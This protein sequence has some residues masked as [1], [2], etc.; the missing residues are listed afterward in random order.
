MNRWELMQ[1]VRKVVA[2]V[3]RT[4]LPQKV[5]KHVEREF[6]SEPVEYKSLSKTDLVTLLIERGIPHNKKSTKAELIKALQEG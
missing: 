4:K 1:D 3:Q 6:I 2:P 5:K